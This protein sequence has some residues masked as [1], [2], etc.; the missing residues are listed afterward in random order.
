MLKGV[1]RKVKALWDE[2]A[3]MG[4]GT[5]ASSIAYFVFLSLIPMIALCISLVSWMGVSEQ[6]VVVFF[7]SITPDA[8]HDLVATLVGDAF[9]RSGV[10]FSI[11][12]LTLLWSASKGTKALRGG[13]NAAY[14]VQETRSAPVVVA[15]SILAVL[16]L[17]IMLATMI[18]FVFSGGINGILSDYF[19]DLKLGELTDLLSP[20]VG[21]ALSV[22]AYN[23]CYAY[24]PAG[25]RRF[26][27]Q[28]PGAVF[29][30]LACDALSFGFRV[31]VDHIG[32]VTMLYG[33]IATVA[34]LLIWMYLISYILLAG[35]FMNR[36][37][38]GRFQ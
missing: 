3:E 16:V 13:L 33:S 25:R 2:F 9:K 32:D 17:G 4:A 38:A 5:C 12:T 29:T 28:L 20:V 22:L 34:L 27:M 24:L 35:G 36:V 19:P 1:W 8:F 7:C 26:V 31:Y 30:A 10:A 11:S 37:V 23:I 6:D 18:Y 21:F 15:I 14:G